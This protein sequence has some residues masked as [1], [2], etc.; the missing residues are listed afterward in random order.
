M[1]PCSLPLLEMAPIV[2]HPA[3]PEAVHAFVPKCVLNSFA[4]GQDSWLCELRRS[5][6]IFVNLKGLIL[7]RDDSSDPGQV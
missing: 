3:G 1:T 4:A 2:Q 7:D 5:S 6:V